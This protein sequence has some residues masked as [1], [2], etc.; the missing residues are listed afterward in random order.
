MIR[1]DCNHKYKVIYESLDSITFKCQKCD[2]VIPYQKSNIWNPHQIE[3]KLKFGIHQENKEIESR[4]TDSDILGINAN[5]NFFDGKHQMHLKIKPYSEDILN[6]EPVEEIFECILCEKKRHYIIGKDTM[7]KLSIDI[8]SYIGN[9]KYSK[10]LSCALFEFILRYK[11]LSVDPDG[12]TLEKLRLY[13]IYPKY[14]EHIKEFEKDKKT[15]IKIFQKYGFIPFIYTRNPLL[16]QINAFPIYQSYQ[17]HSDLLPL[18]IK[19]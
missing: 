10:I 12:V 18:N 5:C 16:R 17:K 14:L 4:Q 15:I 7:E 6:G 13:G 1:K 2:R 19:I 3:E 9:D 8:E 11:K